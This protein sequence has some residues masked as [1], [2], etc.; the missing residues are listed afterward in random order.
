MFAD[1]DSAA[2][3]A[4][5][6]AV[7]PAG[8]HAV[9]AGGLPPPPAPGAAGR[10]DLPQ[11]AHSHHARVQGGYQPAQ[12]W[13][14]WHD[15]VLESINYTFFF[16]RPSSLYGIRTCLFVLYRPPSS[17]LK[18]KQNM[19]YF[20]YKLYRREFTWNLLNYKLCL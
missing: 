11:G 17:R 4:A 10:R 7:C 16:I 18:L 19:L 2:G 3:V 1:P 20:L 13:L 8:P 12:S 6:A 5:P 9:L 15:W 14:H